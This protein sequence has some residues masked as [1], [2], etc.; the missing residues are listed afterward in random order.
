MNLIKYY[1]CFFE[2]EDCASISETITNAEVLKTLRSFKKDKISG[3]DGWTSKFFVHFY[4]L[5]G[6]KATEVVE[7][8]RRSGIISDS[9]NKTYITLIPKPDNPLVSANIIL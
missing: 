7:E 6:T 8:A 5:I 1:L 3:L 4:D 2:P 9:L